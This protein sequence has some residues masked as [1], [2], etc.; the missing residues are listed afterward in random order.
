[1]THELEATTLAQSQAS[2]NAPVYLVKLELDSGNILVHSRLGSITFNGD[3]YLGVG[4]LGS[5]DGIEEASELSRSSVRITLSGIESA[6]ISTVLGEQY[7]GRRASIYAGFVS[8][9]TNALIGTPAL[10]F[11]G[12]MDTA[13]VL[14]SRDSATI[15]VTIE[16]E[17]AD[18]DKPRI[19]RQNDADQQS[20]YPGDSF[21]K[22][23]EQAADKQVFWG[24]S[25]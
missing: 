19:R 24:K 12:K 2:T 21:F 14:I 7:Q 1:M 5:I 15:T 25:A 6:Y 9:T 23:A 13:P 11:A 8:L 3:I 22:L 18:W 17:L 16:N 4:Q 10:L 20:R